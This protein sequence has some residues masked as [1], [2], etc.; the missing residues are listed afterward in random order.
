MTDLW[1]QM[2]SHVRLSHFILMVL[3]NIC[4]SCSLMHTSVMKWEERATALSCGVVSLLGRLCFRF[5]FSV[6][7]TLARA[8]LCLQCWD[9]KHEL[10]PLI[11]LHFLITYLHWYFACR[12]ACVRS[13]EQELRTVVS[14][15]V[16]AGN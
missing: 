13:P 15:H 14:C 2:P 3:H 12:Y 10:L 9:C 8:G 6:F 11:F 7:E 5:L 1:L 4:I 16:G